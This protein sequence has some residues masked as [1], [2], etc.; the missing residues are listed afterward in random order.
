[1]GDVALKDINTSVVHL[2]LG[3]SISQIRGAF[4]GVIGYRGLFYR[5]YLGFKVGGL[6]KLGV[7]FSGS[8]C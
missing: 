3:R 6:P 8:P 2:A 7:P 5:G 4:K 1:M